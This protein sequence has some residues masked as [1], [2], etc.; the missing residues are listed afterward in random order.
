M[1]SGSVRLNR[2]KLSLEAFAIARCTAGSARKLPDLPAGYASKFGINNLD[3]LNYSS[4]RVL[5][6]TKSD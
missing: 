3:E 4:S 5:S 1:L 6:S 2:C